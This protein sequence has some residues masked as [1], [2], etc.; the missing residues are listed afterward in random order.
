MHTRP[1]T[2]AEDSTITRKTGQRFRQRLLRV[3]A[4]DALPLTLKHER[5]YILPTPRG[6]AFVAVSL[7]MI[8]A[9]M[10]Y[11]LNLGYALSFIMVGLFA[12][13]LLST[14]LNLSHLTIASITSHDTFA[15][16]AVEYHIAL[17]ES[18]NKTRYSITLGG[19]QDNTIVDVKAGGSA[20]LVLRHSDTRRGEHALGRMTISSD[21]PLGL[22]RGWGYIH[23]PTQS[24]IYPKPES[25]VAALPVTRDSQPGAK[26]QT[27]QEREFDQLKRYQDT[28]SPASVAWKTVASGRG[29][30]SKE[31]T[32]AEAS[33]ELKFAW[34]DTSDLADTELRLSRL[35][36]WILQ[37]DASVNPYQLILPHHTTATALGPEHKRHCLRLLA[38]F[39]SAG[40]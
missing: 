18:R 37:A 21:F 6:L 20:L 39:R 30:F 33:R 16:S 32:S 35:C 5:I 24:F 3:N 4:N 10:N 12:S 19:M 27:P 34:S 8:L 31:F 11:G 25:P 26:T 40:R 15:G 28:D 36:A 2:Y 1:A 9:S 14:F 38:G 29:W 22:W 7:V 17:A 23:A 13:C